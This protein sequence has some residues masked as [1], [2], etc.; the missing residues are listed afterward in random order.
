[1]IRI[2]PFHFL[3][4][5]LVHSLFRSLFAL[6]AMAAR[7]KVAVITGTSSG[8]GAYL[9]AILA[10]NGYLTYATMRTPSQRW[11]C[12]RGERR[13]WKGLENKYFLFITLNLN[14]FTFVRFSRS[15]LE[16]A[17]Q[18]L[19]VETDQFDSKGPVSKSGI[20]I[21]AMD[22]SQEN[23]VASCL[24]EIFHETDRVV[25]VCVNNAGYSEGGG[26]ESIS[27]PNARKQFETNFFGLVKVGTFE[28]ESEK[29][30]FPSFGSI[31]FCYLYSHHLSHTHLS[32][33]SSPG[34]PNDPPSDA[35]ERKWKDDCRLLCWRHQRSAVQ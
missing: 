12:L 6:W 25:D 32:L 5:S 9:S 13:L 15:G 18:E 16:E 2:P 31:F 11:V 19:G 10:K 27:V 23:S 29:K 8:V 24:E 1:M 14:T 22:V 33:S 28:G 17:C 26:V 30:L 3:F 20:R 35:R 7:V 4:L 34:H 21:R